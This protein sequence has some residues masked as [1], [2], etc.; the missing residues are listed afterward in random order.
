M[1]N[2]SYLEILNQ[3]RQLATSENAVQLRVLSNVVIDSLKEILEVTASREGIDISVGIGNFDNVVQD[4]LTCQGADVVIVFFELG[5]IP[6]WNHVD[7]SR[8]WQEQLTSRSEEF[9]RTATLVLE[10]LRSTSLVL[11]SRLS[12]I[13]ISEKF[14][15]DSYGKFF[16]D[17]VNSRLETI[18]P[19]NAV[20]IDI[21]KA[22]IIGG[23]QKSINYRD[24]YTLKAPFT[25]RFLVNY[26]NL[27][28]PLLR[29]Y[30]GG[31]K[32]VLVLDGDNTLWGG[33]IGEDGLAGIDLSP[34]TPL[35]R[36]YLDCQR[37][38]LELAQNG[39]LLAICSKNNEPEVFQ[40]LEEHP[41]QILRKEHFVAFKINWED[42]ATNI[43]KISEALNLGLNSFVF[44]DD[45][46]FEVEL[47][48]RMLPMVQAFL[49]PENKFLY[50]DKLSFVCQQ[51]FK[52]TDTI[53][54]QNRTGMY[55]QEQKRSKAIDR[56]DSLEDYLR[57][58]QL[59]VKV[60]TNSPGHYARLSQMTQKT[61]QFNL[62]M[63]R[64]SEKEV[65]E[66][67]N[68]PNDLV[69]SLNAEDRFGDYGVVGF[70][71]VSWGDNN[72]VQASLD[73]FLLSCRALGRGIEN[74]F[75]DII[76]VTVAELGIPALD[77]K[78]LPTGR[79]EQ[80]REFLTNCGFE[81]QGE[82]GGYA[83]I[84]LDLAKYVPIGKE[85]IEVNRAN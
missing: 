16:S 3:H 21:D 12:E 13:T 42:K 24:R 5:E 40:L 61:N 44:L 1:F 58:L 79:N 76:V 19:S 29:G 54:D 39:V 48:E 66:R 53:E 63:L 51:F 28:I 41:D 37:R 71:L 26:S 9:V 6:G 4:S 62:S 75:L 70:S 60:C 65:E 77:G 7:H 25:V 38:I 47:V 69:F 59:K 20:L 27:I 73:L 11:F 34:Q 82:T 18:L 52:S 35:G 67:S 55:L 84:F 14:L 30:A 46:P 68:S 64:L 43:R 17:R 23:I 83:R 56:F 72:K 22:F 49:V 85:Y 15:G 57:S 31:A 8:P 45:S 33:I 2:T 10:N 74:S 36:V 81:W 80:V 78:F 32:K 50:P